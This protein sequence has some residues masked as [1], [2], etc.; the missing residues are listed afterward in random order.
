MTIADELRKRIELGQFP[1]AETLITKLGNSFSGCEIWQFIE[2]PYYP[3]DIESSRIMK[4]QLVEVGFKPVTVMRKGKN[5]DGWRMTSS[6]FFSLSEVNRK[7][8]RE[9]VARWPIGIKHKRRIPTAEIMQVIGITGGGQRNARISKGISTFMSELRFDHGT[10]W[11]A[12]IEKNVSGYIERGLDFGSLK[13][14][15]DQ[16]IKQKTEAEKQKMAI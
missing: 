12:A 3:Q 5:R 2:L 13:Y 14:K 16:K 11:Y 4:H 7:Q 1:N 10:V 8:I 15:V 6:S 9:L